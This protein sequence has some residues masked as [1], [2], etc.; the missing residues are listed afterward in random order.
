MEDK[1]LQQA[2]QRE[3]DW[4]PQVNSAHIGVAARNGAVILTGHV[5]SYSEK[6]AA[7]KATERVYGVKAV[8]DELEVKLPGANVR[9]D[10]DIAASIAQT[11]RWHSLVP[12]TVEAEVRKGVVTLRGEVEW[13]YQRSAAERAV[14]NVIGVRSVVNLISVKPRVKPS[15]V[16]ERITESFKRSATLDAKSISVLTQNGTVR[17]SGRVHSLWERRTAEEA[18]RAAPGVSE[19]ENDLVV[20]P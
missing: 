16:K 13:G 14:R 11:L 19:V 5:S 2:V 4:D 3:L 6:Y 18:A 20:T 12:D 8:A 1:Q 10:S 7:V 9:E 15:D 17:L